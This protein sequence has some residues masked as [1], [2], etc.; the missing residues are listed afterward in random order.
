MARHFMIEREQVGLEI[1]AKKCRQFSQDCL[2]F[3]EHVLDMAL[4]IEARE[5]D[6]FMVRTLLANAAEWEHDAQVFLQA[7]EDPRRVDTASRP[8]GGVLLTYY[9]DRT[10]PAH[11]EVQ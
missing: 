11:I 4:Q 7:A 6:T 1:T 3:A 5:G 10:R 9:Y 8:R 2:R